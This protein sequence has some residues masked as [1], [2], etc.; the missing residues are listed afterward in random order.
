MKPTHRF[1][2]LSARLSLGLCMQSNA[3][4]DLEQHVIRSRVRWVVFIVR[5]TNYTTTTSKAEPI[6]AETAVA[7]LM[8]PK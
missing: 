2:V 8:T 1:A 3:A 6:F 5:D 4:A 7:L